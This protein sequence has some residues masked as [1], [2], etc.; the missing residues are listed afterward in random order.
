MA[1]E[2]VTA[3]GRLGHFFASEDVFG[4]E[5]DFISSA[6]GLTSAYAPLS[7][8]IFSEAVY[9]V[10]SEPQ[11]EGALFTHGFTYSG[12][13]VSCAAGLANIEI[14]EREDICGHV[15]KVGPYLE[16]QLESTARSAD[17]R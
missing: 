5:P 17:C 10:L 3:F 13:P 14:M 6:K 11:A 9:D 15:R 12:H 7:A 2:V 1:D 4:I 16:K 8:S